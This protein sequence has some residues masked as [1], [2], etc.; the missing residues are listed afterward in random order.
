MRSHQCVRAWLRL[1]P[2][3]LAATT[4]LGFAPPAH[5]ATDPLTTGQ[6]GL[7]LVKARAAWAVGRG[8]GVTIAVVDSGTDLA[9]EDLAANVV[10]GK[11][12]VSDSPQDD[13]GHGTHVS[14]IAAGVG[15][16]GRGISGVAPAAKVMP[17]KVLTP[18]GG[19]SGDVADGI[20][21]AA[22]SGAAV[23]NLSLGGDVPLVGA[24]S[25]IPDAVRYAWSKGSICVLAA[26][27]NS[28]PLSDY[29]NLPAI[30]VTAVDR[31]DRQA[32][33]ATSIGGAKWG[34][35]A[36]G[37]AGNG[38]AGD[39]VLSTF[40]SAGKANSY[41]TLAGT[42]MA[43]PF[44]SGAAAILRGL[45][46]SPQATVDRLLSSA[47]DI[48]ASG[49]DGTFGS[50]RLD[51]ARAVAGRGAPGPTPTTPGAVTTSPAR[52]GSPTTRGARPSTSAASSPSTSPSP[53]DAVMSSTESPTTT[54]PQER[55]ALRT[56]DS[57]DGGSSDRGTNPALLA[58]GFVAVMS[59][60]TLTLWSWRSR[61]RS[62][63]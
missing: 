28:L 24:F 61:Q 31:Q 1:L 33:Y 36:P 30:V 38:N 53:D 45:G 4:V 23:I 35:A 15:E 57:G 27:N 19:N 14:G 12:Y 13:D 16:N 6:W 41:G 58:G 40:W 29:G 43:A 56:A 7:D 44:V 10:A 60:A 59:A 46:L 8:A 11:S 51:V 3:V 54:V 55:D 17:V 9:H 2:V 63:V 32:G 52:S 47:A 42:S 25:S 50:G 39:D 37:G 5:A 21:F 18:D 48:G 49:R 26:G 20:R 34:M 22:D 62:L